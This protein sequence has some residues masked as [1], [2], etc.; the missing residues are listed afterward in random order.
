MSLPVATTTIRTWRKDSEVTSNDDPWE[1]GY[2]DDPLSANDFAILDE[3]IRAVVSVGG[4]TYAGRSVGPGDSEQVNFS[5]LA[6]PCDLQ[7]LDEVEDELTGQRYAVEWV[8]HNPGVAGILAS[9]RAGLSTRKG[10]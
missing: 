4:G 1:D 2:P 10:A 6:D 9:T 7:Y 5:L 8:V 3:K